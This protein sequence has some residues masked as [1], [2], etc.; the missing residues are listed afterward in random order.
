MVEA[1]KLNYP[2]REIADAA[3]ALQ[4]E[5][6]GGERIVVG[7]NRYALEQRGADP[8]AAHRPRARAASRSAACRPR[9]RD[10]TA[11]SSS[12]RWRRSARMRRMRTAT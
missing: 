5:I 7:V 10:A 1:V 2:Q 11:P 4:Q 9:A 8:H 6:D 3:F 12:V